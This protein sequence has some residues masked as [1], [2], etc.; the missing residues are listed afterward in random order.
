VRGRGVMEKCTYCT[1]RINKVRIEAKKEGREIRDGEI[2]VACE[3]ACPTQ[4]IVFGDI[5][6]PN[7]RV[8]K[9]RGEPQDYSLLAD[10]NTRPRT[11]YMARLR[12]PN[13][14]IEGDTKTAGEANTTREAAPGASRETP[15]EGTVPAAEPTAAPSATPTASPTPEAIVPSP[16]PAA[17]P[18]PT[19]TPAAGR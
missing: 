15:P 17:S 12:N 11:T 3:Q 9:L 1:Q 6:D 13:P 18:S 4:A 10:L 16:S 5:N 19:A 8:L 2:V 7:S 14:A